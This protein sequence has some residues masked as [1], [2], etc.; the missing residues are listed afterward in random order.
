MEG[1]TTTL[2]WRR[3]ST[4]TAATNQSISNNNALAGWWDCTSGT[5][6]RA[7]TIG[8]HR[9]W[10]TAWWW[11]SVVGWTDDRKKVNDA[12]I[13]GKCLFDTPHIHAAGEALCVCRTSTSLYGRYD[14][15]SSVQGKKDDVTE[16]ILSI[17]DSMIFEY[18]MHV[19]EYYN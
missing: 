19:L 18:S 6:V 16:D 4:K 2:R 10:C 14:S 5:S 11:Y 1:V 7:T 9:L 12:T 15:F 13:F 3:A 8:Q 17:V